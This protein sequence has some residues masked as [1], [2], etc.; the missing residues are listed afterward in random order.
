MMTAKGAVAPP[1]IAMAHMGRIGQVVPVRH[2]P[3]CKITLKPQQA[4]LWRRLGGIAVAGF[5]GQGGKKSPSAP[6]L[7]PQTGAFI[8]LGLFE[9]TV[10]QAGQRRRRLPSGVWLA[11]KCSS[12]IMSRASQL[13]ASSPS[14]CAKF[15][16]RSTAGWIARASHGAA[17]CRTGHWRHRGIDLCTSAGS[18]EKQGHRPKAGGR[19]GD[20]DIGR[21]GNKAVHVLGDGD[22]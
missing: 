7:R 21:P 13:R 6:S 16:L 17:R 14:L 9:R 22:V 18:I 2:Q 11:A 10:A 15:G 1:G 8:L 4:H 3:A 5:D 12:S 19:L 20:D